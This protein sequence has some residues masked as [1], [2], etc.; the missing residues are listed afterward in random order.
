MCFLFDLFLSGRVLPCKKF[1]ILPKTNVIF[2]LYY[3]SFF[4]ASLLFSENNMCSS[5][6]LKVMLVV[7]RRTK[8]H[9]VYQ[10]LKMLM[11]VCCFCNPL[12]E[13]V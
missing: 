4:G 5:G 6:R 2:V 3:S 1:G 12:Q 11:Q 13:F 8:E 10:Y 7:S 9:M